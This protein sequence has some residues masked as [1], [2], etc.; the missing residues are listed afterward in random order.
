M[1][2]ENNEL[3]ENFLSRWSKKKS[4]QKTQIENPKTKQID[5]ESSTETENQSTLA[6]ENDK[7]NDEELLKKYNLPKIGRAHV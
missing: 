3:E 5:P 6:E 1:E 2:E 4:K 7:L